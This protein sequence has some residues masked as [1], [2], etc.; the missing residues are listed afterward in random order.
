MLSENGDLTAFEKE[1]DQSKAHRPN[2][3]CAKLLTDFPPLKGTALPWLLR[4]NLKV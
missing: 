1:H 2:G 3:S 4:D